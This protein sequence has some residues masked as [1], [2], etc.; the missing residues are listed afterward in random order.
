MNPSHIITYVFIAVVLVLVL[1]MILFPMKPIGTKGR[2]IIDNRFRYNQSLVYDNQ[3]NKFTASYR[4]NT[5]T[6][7]TPE[8]SQEVIYEDQDSGLTGYLAID[9]Q[10]TLY[11]TNEEPAIIKIENPGTASQTVITIS[12]ADIDTD[13]CS[14]AVTANGNIHFTDMDGNLYC[15]RKTEHGYSKRDSVTNKY[16]PSDDLDSD[17]S[18]VAIGDKIYVVCNDGGDTYI[19]EL[20]YSKEDGY[21]ELNN[22][23][24]IFDL[25]SSSSYNGAYI[26]TT[27]G[28]HVWS[29]YYYGNDIVY[30]KLKKDLSDFTEMDSDDL[31]SCVSDYVIDSN[32]FNIDWFGVKD[33]K[34][35]ILIE[36]TGDYRH[37]NRMYE[38]K[39]EKDEMKSGKLVLVAASDVNSDDQGVCVSTATNGK[40]V[41]MA[42]Y[43]GGEYLRR[44]VSVDEHGKYRVYKSRHLFNNYRYRVTCLAM[45]S[46]NRLFVGYINTANDQNKI[47][48]FNTKGGKILSDTLKTNG[49]T[50][51]R[52]ISSITVDESSGE[53]KG[54]FINTYHGII[55]KLKFHKM[56]DFEDATADVIVDDYL[57]GSIVM[58]GDDLI[59]SGRMTG[60]LV[61]IENPWG[62]CPRRV[63]LDSGVTVAGALAVVDNKILVVDQE[64]Q[65]VLDTQCGHYLP[66][67][68]NSI[69][70]N[71]EFDDWYTVQQNMSTGGDKLIVTEL[72]SVTGISGYRT[73][74]FQL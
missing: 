61:K 48:C 12:V 9:S 71:Y 69:G 51:I 72:G 65:K 52:E 59:A 8:G 49:D 68:F 23:E 60:E 3:G 41:F 73:I 30:I 14:L 7:I 62:H 66:F 39:L 17:T 45:D 33:G 36:E 22:S 19:Q 16:V 4:Y 21:L 28:E 54:L 50:F 35:H 55:N 2:K 44:I 56:S 20:K 18:V 26:L 15:V 31:S 25:I 37:F 1:F 24:V 64:A 67:N 32:N 5:V 27:D 10:G 74:I 70:F 34:M 13:A 47:A 57:F 38:V 40:D 43:A 29:G 63:P 6:M 46:K 58:K 53:L 11:A 42:Y